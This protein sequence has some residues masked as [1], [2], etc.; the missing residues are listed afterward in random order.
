MAGVACESVQMTTGSS[1]GAPS[2]CINDSRVTQRHQLS[3]GTA[4]YI[5]RWGPEL[6][7][8]AGGQDDQRAAPSRRYS[9]LR[10]AV[11]PDPDRVSWSGR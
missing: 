9:S 6:L 4:A 5:T 10:G 2:S 8:D 11:T 1:T 3:T 7:F